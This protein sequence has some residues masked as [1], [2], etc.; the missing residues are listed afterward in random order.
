[1]TTLFVKR[2]QCEEQL[3]PADAGACLEAQSDELPVDCTNWP[4][5]PYH[6]RVRFRIGHIQAEIWLKFYVA[7]TRI[8]A[9]ETVFNGAVSQD[10]AVEF[11]ISFDKANYYNFE[12]NCIGTAHLAYGPT[13]N[14]RRFVSPALVESMTIEPSLGKQPFEEKSGVFE[15]TLM[16]KIPVQ[17][18]AFDR[19]ATLSGR[20]ASANFY[21]VGNGLSVPHYMTW[22]PVNTANPDYHR[23]EFFGGV[24][25]E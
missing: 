21:K 8:R 10:S 18:F 11:F 7:E 2:I 17:C 20:D 3:S 9:R 13:R 1:M 15:W 5:F 25:F 22:R 4:Q 16:V 14:N 23:P 24:R 19:I 6:P 12:F